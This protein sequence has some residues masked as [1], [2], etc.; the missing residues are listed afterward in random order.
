MARLIKADLAFTLAWLNQ[1][2]FDIWEEESGRHYFTLLVQA[3][4]LAQAAEWLS[5]CGQGG[6]A[7]TCTNA[8]EGVLTRL[9]SFWDDARGFY[10]SR[11]DVEN[12]AG[13]KDLDIA[14]ILGVTHAGRSGGR[15]SVLD[16]RAQA[17]LANLEEMFEAEYAIN[18]DRPAGTGPA[19]G[20][21][22]NDTYYSGG[23]YYFAT[24]AAAEFYFTLAEALQSGGEMPAVPANSRFLQ[25]LAGTNEAKKSAQFASAAIR[26]GDA[27]MET[28]RM[29]TPESG[30]LSEQFDH[31]TG[32]QSS[33]KRLTWSY[34]AFV[35]ACSRRS[36]CVHGPG[37]SAST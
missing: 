10:R 26:R 19:L 16:P 31:T 27:I 33:A 11:T 7:R 13:G 1:P 28:V 4:A 25:R 15:H 12:G 8:G 37:G 9:D 18:R 23:A 5:G 32:E 6:R 30:E 20:R 29:F 14:V 3:Q 17:T 35:T 24:L 2:S 22:A 21:Y 36:R 34:A